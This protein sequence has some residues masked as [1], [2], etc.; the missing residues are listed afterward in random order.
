MAV[1]ST[2]TAEHYPWG[3]ACDGWHLLRDNG[4]GVIEERMPPGSVEQRH[5]HRHARQFFYVLAG[6]AVLELDGC[7]HTLDAGQGLHVPPGSVHQM[8]NDSAAD[9]RFLLVSSPHSH[10]DREQA[11]LLEALR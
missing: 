11:P 6:Q 10:G 9:L 8:R 3:E 2:D 7:R 1:I 4:L 5:L